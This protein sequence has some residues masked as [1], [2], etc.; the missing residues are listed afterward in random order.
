MLKISK[1]FL[2]LLTAAL[3][4]IPGV[5][6]LAQT[7]QEKGLEIAIATDKAN[8]GWGDS[9]S[10]LKMIMSNAQG[11]TSIREL[12]LKNLEVTDEG[13]GDKSLSIFDRPRDVEGTAF[14]SHTKVLE[15][16]DQWLLLPALG[17]VKRISSANKSGPFMG[18]EFAYEDILSPE[19]AK[20]SYVYLRDE[21]CGALTCY[22]I[23]RTPLYENSGYTK[24]IVW[25]DQAE[26]RYMKIA[27]YDRKDSHLKTLTYSDYQQYLGKYW[28]A[29]TFQ[30]DNHQ[31]GKA[32]T[33]SYS[34]YVFQTGL[35]D[36]DFTSSRLSKMR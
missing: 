13:L 8:E 27:F 11:Q 10:E 14:L 36:K 16:D 4:V 31:N 19:V 21:A 28:R 1:S 20:Y 34:N 2:F 6:A 32:T 25:I 5:S 29:H 12:R 15:A 35:D 17:R 33:L 30:M 18:S 23:E 9:T 26:Y 22:V 3:I 7:A 24:Q